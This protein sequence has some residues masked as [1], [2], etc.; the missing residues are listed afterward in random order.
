MLLIA[1]LL[2]VVGMGNL[3]VGQSKCSHYSKVLREASTPSK[4]HPHGKHA[5]DS[6]YVKELQSRSSY[7]R[8][9]RVGGLCLL[10]LGLGLMLLHL[11]R[12]TAGARSAPAL[13]HEPPPGHMESRIHAIRHD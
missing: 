13:T 3:W 12:R 6:L 5:P 2:V 10:S 8:I 7:Y 9:V 1:A 4:S 11:I